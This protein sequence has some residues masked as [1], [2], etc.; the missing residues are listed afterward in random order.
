M[1]EDADWQNEDVTFA[2][3]VICQERRKEIVDLFLSGGS[4]EDLCS[5]AA[6]DD[7]QIFFVCHADLESLKNAL[8]EI[9][10]IQIGPNE[11]DVDEQYFRK[12][13][14]MLCMFNNVY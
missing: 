3:E 7:R 11:L 8:S 4:F 12:D 2:R 10:E 13:G 1:P 5:N 14:A 6:K 9:Y